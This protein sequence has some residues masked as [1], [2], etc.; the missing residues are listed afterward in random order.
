M[1][2]LAPL[3]TISFSVMANFLPHSTPFY[4]GFYLAQFFFLGMIL[5]QY[6]KSIHVT[7]KAISTV[8]LGTI[9]SYSAL[10]IFSITS[11]LL[12][13]LC[14]LVGLRVQLG[15][16]RNVDYSYGVYLHAGPITHLVVLVI[17]KVQLPLLAGYVLSLIL[18]I[19]AGFLSW[20][21]IES[22][23]SNRKPKSKPKI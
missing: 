16:S 7:L 17:K 9:L 12:T 21:M 4:M 23:F 14:L 8:A 22:R 10:K 6:R 20:H 1:K 13:L 15:R 5:W 2:V 11:A 19:A 3:L 18:S